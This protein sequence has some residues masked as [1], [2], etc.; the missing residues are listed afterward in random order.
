MT[1]TTIA[2]ELVIERESGKNKNINFRVYNT[3]LYLF[4]SQ[5]VT[6]ETC[7]ARFQMHILLRQLLLLLLTWK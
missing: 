1:T 5:I 2:F 7:L 6:C 3:I 4:H